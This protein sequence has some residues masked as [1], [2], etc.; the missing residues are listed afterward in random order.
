MLIDMPHHAFVSYIPQDRQVATA[1]CDSLESNSIK[2][3]IEHRDIIPDMRLAKER[4]EAIVVSRVLVAVLSK[5][6]IRSN[7]VIQDISSAIL[8]DI[9]ILVVRTENVPVTGLAESYASSLHWFDAFPAPIEGYSYELAGEAKA[10]IADKID[11]NRV[12]AAI[13]ASLD[14]WRTEVN[15]DRKRELLEQS[16]QSVEKT[17]RYSVIGFVW[18]CMDAW[19]GENEPDLQEEL[20]E[21]SRAILEDNLRF[22]RE[23]VLG[24]LLAWREEDTP[25]LQSRILEHSRSVVDRNSRYSMAEFIWACYT[26]W[27]REEEPGLQHQLLKHSSSLVD[28]S[29]KDAVSIY[30]ITLLDAWRQEENSKLKQRILEF[31]PSVVSE[32]GQN[33]VRGFM[34]GCLF[35]WH[36]ESDP[37]TRKEILAYS[38]QVSQSLSAK[39]H[40][41]I[42]QEM[43]AFSA[44]IVD[45]RLREE[46]DSFMQSLRQ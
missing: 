23:F 14:Q 36:K 1:V 18:A 17:S 5:G 4:A 2:C 34:K 20:L 30:V 28:A 3:W 46:L 6:S 39:M 43:V 37:R 16:L 7:T 9:P 19:L 24:C 29:N 42:S 27:R 45:S 22:V 12:R 32:G 26:A 33:S 25:G 8:R 41:D 13:K 44:S 38:W 35:V 10:L 15:P 40:V 21:H 11:T 31:I